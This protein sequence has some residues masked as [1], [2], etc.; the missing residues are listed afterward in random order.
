M[1]Q[2]TLQSAPWPG[3]IMGGIID[4]CGQSRCFSSKGIWARHIWL[5]EPAFSTTRHAVSTIQNNNLK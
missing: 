3:G 1:K 4:V 2:W 5:V